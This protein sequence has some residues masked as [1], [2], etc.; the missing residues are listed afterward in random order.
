MLN[1]KI[2]NEVLLIIFDYLETKEAY[3]LSL[4]NKNAYIVYDYYINTK[5][6]NNPLLYEYYNIRIIN[7]ETQTFF[8][9]KSY[10]FVNFINPFKNNNYFFICKIYLHEIYNCNYF[11]K[12]GYLKFYLGLNKLDTNI[13]SAKIIYKNKNTNGSKNK[14]LTL[15]RKYILISRFK[16][17]PI[18][19]MRELY[20]KK[21]INNL[22][23]N[24]NNNIINRNEKFSNNYLFGP[25]T[26]FEYNPIDEIKRYEKQKFNK[27]HD[28]WIVIATFDPNIILPNNEITNEMIS[29]V[30]RKIH[31]NEMKFDNVYVVYNNDKN[32]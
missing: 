16:I 23:E 12:N 31:L 3:N 7:N 9:T 4:I 25:P 1:S 26:Y 32:K 14:I 6:I 28:D 30:I 5:N 27:I 8:K 17:L 15:N 13:Y 21:N 24:H 22:I 29:F 10:M 2:P 20:I 11:P 18:S 19:D